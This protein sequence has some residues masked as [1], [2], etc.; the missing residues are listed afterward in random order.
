MNCA[1]ITSDQFLLKMDDKDFDKVID[2]NLKVTKKH[3]I[4]QMFVI[5]F[6]IL[7]YFFMLHLFCVFFYFFS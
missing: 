1:G 4:V 2:I 6:Y 7:F 3:C 5:E